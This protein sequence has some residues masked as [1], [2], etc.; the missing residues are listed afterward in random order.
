[1][2][3]EPAVLTSTAGAWRL[4]VDGYFAWLRAG[5][6]G[7]RSLAVRKCHLDQ[8]R[9]MYPGTPPAGLTA[10]DLAR[11]VGQPGL[12]PESRK[13]RRASVRGMFGWM[14][15]AGLVDHSAARTLRPVR[16]P[17]S[18]PRPAPDDVLNAALARAGERERLMLLLGAYAGLRCC[19]IAQVHTE[20]VIGDTLRVTGKGGKERE[21]PLHPVL[22]AE[23]AKIP[24]GWVFPGR[25]DFDMPGRGRGGAPYIGHLSAQHIS[26]LLRD[27]LPAGW[28]AH[29]LRHRFA[30]LAYANGGRDLLAVQALLGHSKPETTAR[31][32]AVPDGALRAGVMGAGPT[33]A[34]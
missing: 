9:R 13:S 32:C 7:H 17:Q 18:K 15:E 22:A 23:L 12:A 28:T 4:A 31:Y 20:D 14:A 33:L 2:T 26:D 24:P 25:I 10:D 1:V 11:F 16:I 3:A 21:I 34:P 19:E 29:K 27:L 6:V 5:G 30:S 8:L